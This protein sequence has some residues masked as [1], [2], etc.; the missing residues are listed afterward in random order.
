M[1]IIPVVDILDGQAVRGVGGRRDEYRPLRSQICT[2]SQPV[3]VVRQVRDAFG[4]TEWYVAD[5]DAIVHRRPNVA[6][7]QQL[8]AL[9]VTALLDAGL[10]TAE[11]LANFTLPHGFTLIAGLETMASPAEL[12][13]CLA[14]REPADLV[15]SLD[16]KQGRSCSTS[17]HW[18]DAPLDIARLVAHMGIR[19][20]IVL[21]LADVGMETG[22]STDDL[23]RQIRAEFPNLALIG[24]GG[25]RSP[26]DLTRLAELGLSGVLVASALH[27]GRLTAADVAAVQLEL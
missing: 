13:A 11:E 25:V 21:D 1:Q 22:V 24:G 2:S 4:L 27:D 5:L 6:I 26:G 9:G 19:R 7:Y 10:H 12:Q 20:I 15:F 3:E 8:A 14:V 16:L 23:C 18:P 17:G